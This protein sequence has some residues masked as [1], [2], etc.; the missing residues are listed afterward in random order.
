MRQQSDDVS[1]LCGGARLAPERRRKTADVRER[2]GS[3]GEKK[4]DR[5]AAEDQNRH[6]FFDGA[7]E[8]EGEERAAQQDFIGDRIE[9]GADAR[10]CLQFAREQSVERVGDPRDE[11]QRERDPVFT[12]PEFQKKERSED[13]PRGA[14][15]IGNQLQPFM[16][17]YF[18]RRGSGAYFAAPS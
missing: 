11:A 15:Q 17:A 5:V 14:Q 6:P 2:E 18:A 12:P 8:R 7:V 3:P 1:D 10:G 16:I 4:N 9:I 13:Q